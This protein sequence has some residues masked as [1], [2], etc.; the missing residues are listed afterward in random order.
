MFDIK[1]N[2]HFQ[3][4]LKISGTN[5]RWWLDSLSWQSR[6]PVRPRRTGWTSF[7][8]PGEEGLQVATVGAPKPQGF[9]Q[10]T[11]RDSQRLEG[12]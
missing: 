4:E 3:R 9:Q 12:W 11:L 10:V 8:S 5:D 7:V 2:F 6:H 1:D